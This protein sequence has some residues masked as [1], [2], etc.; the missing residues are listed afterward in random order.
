M[1]K[2][3]WI[4]CAVLLLNSASAYMI[5]DYPAMF[6]EDGEFTATIVKG[7]QRDSAEIAAAN[8]I[9][10]SLPK[11]GKQ[12]PRNMPLPYY[13]YRAEP[14]PATIILTDE[15]V[16]E[17]DEI[18]IGTPCANARVRELLDIPQDQCKTFFSQQ[19]HLEL[20]ED[21]YQHLVITGSEAGRVLDAAKTLTDPRH[22]LKLRVQKAPI[23]RVYYR[24]SYQINGRD[25][26]DIGE[27]IGAVTPTLY[28]GYPYVTYRPYQETTGSRYGVI[29]QKDSRFY[30]ETRSINVLG[31]RFYVQKA[32]Q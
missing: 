3:G 14:V 8:L 7:S 1:K 32:A 31:S 17:G 9:I 22:R 28:T 6:F 15:Q 21:D 29:V 4:V 19:G 5:A 30:G 20:I 25:V 27:T 12:M 11:A 10:H 2:W 13:R 18:V 16:S 24:T 26:L 23:R